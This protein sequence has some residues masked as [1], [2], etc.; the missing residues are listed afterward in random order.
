MRQHGGV[1]AR[2]EVRLLGGFSVRRGGEE[3]APGAFRGRLVRSLIRVLL[4]RRG[5]FVSHD[6]LA[7]ALWPGRMPA[8]P[9]ANLKVLVNRARA[10]L[11][12][13]ALI[14][15]G[16]G[17]YSFTGGDACRV[18]AEEFVA[19]AA[20]GRR[21]LHEGDAV[22]AL[23]V[24]G[25]A[26]E[27]WG[28]EPLPEEAYEDWAREYRAGLARAHLQAV[29]DA[30][31]AA[32]AVGE[33][34]DAV[35]LA[36]VATTREPLREV[37]H[38]LLAEAQVASGDVVGALRTIDGLRRRLGHET[39]LEPSA[40]ILDLERR[41][42]RGHS[43]P[44]PVR[45]KAARPSRPA[46]GGQLTFVGRNAELASVLAAIGE[47][48]PGV[49]VVTGPAGAGKSRLL[50]EAASRCA[51]SVVSVRAFQAERNEP[52]SLARALLRDALSLDLAAA[53]SLADRT[54]AAL[55]DLLP[56]LE[57]LRPL[58]VAVVDPE[59]R[60]ALAVE[61]AV[62]LVS[63]VAAK[64]LLV[65]VDDLQWADPTSI[66]LLGLIG[67]RVPAAALALSYRPTEVQPEGPLG[68]FLED[69]GAARSVTEV[70]VGPFSPSILGELV[71][72]PVL[73]ESLARQTDGTPLAVSEV[74][75]RL[76]DD[77]AIALEAD[78]RWRPVRPGVAE[79]AGTIAREGQRR[80]IERRAAR[81]PPGERETLALLALLGREVPA[82]LLAAARNC[83]EAV[84][85]DELDGLARTG[86]IRLGDAGWATA[87]DLIAEAVTDALGREER[88]RLHHQLARALA[89][90][91]EDPAEVARHLAEAGDRAAAAEAFAAA[92]GQRMERYAA[93]ETA[94]LADAGLAL[95]PAGALRV[96]LL[97][98]RA[99]ARNMQ[100]DGIGARHDLRRALDELRDERDRSRLLTKLAIFSVSQ[101]ASEATALAEAAIAEAGSDLRA[102]ANALVAAG[103][104]VG[105]SDRTAEA[106]V[107]ITE[108]RLLFEDA[109]DSRGLAST[110]DAQANAL[111]VRGRLAEAVPFYQRAARLYR[112]TGQLAKVGW[113][114]LIEAF[115]LNM[116]GRREAARA[117]CAEAL[118]VERA[119]GQI[120]GEAGC[121]V[122][123]ADIAI[124]SGDVDDARRRLP[125]ALRLS[126]AAGNLEFI[127]YALILAGRVARADGDPKAAES[128]FQQALGA[129]TGLPLWEAQAAAH[130]ADLYLSRNN[131][132][133]A[134]AF[135]R[136]ACAGRVGPGP[137]EGR[138]LLAETA[139]ARGDPGAEAQARQ[140]LQAAATTDYAPSPNRLRLQ[141]RLDEGKMGGPQPMAS[142]RLRRVFMFT[143]I[144]GSSNLV[145]L[146][147]DEA[148]DHLLRW[149]DHTLRDLFA[150]HAGEEINRLG[151]GF[152]VAFEGPEAA[153][154]CAIAIQQALSAHRRDHGFAP[155]VRIGI[156]TAEATHQDGDYQ[157]QGVHQA[158]RIGS[159]ASAGEILVSRSTLGDL[160]RFRCSPPRAIALKGFSD[161]VLVVAVE[162]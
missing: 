9:V 65:A 151:D 139:F 162:W 43:G 104:A 3:I 108:A 146:L 105:A 50:Q 121:L 73:A 31:R 76:A 69:L 20:D 78:G 59:S 17:G 122:G 148:W 72:D 137:I 81:R 153:V 84:V 25:P 2:T 131:F 60:R 41:I 62:R 123:L 57:E 96:A 144:V 21:R 117:R 30:A 89:G 47:S 22:G 80:G 6:V 63:V 98:R 152:F 91:E 126:R 125:D 141:R 119:L 99:D 154:S 18:D 158:A 54:A 115:A 53:A 112:D 106:D 10:G 79:L 34:D 103:F 118:E 14:V 28:G 155:V 44:A 149:H 113:P 142:T 24:L 134:E 4:T 49:T 128:A 88:G 70:G 46:F 48:P 85:L 150:R 94:T 107:F 61:G 90:A 156:H 58:T 39:G 56:E 7:E 74:I 143:D 87:H 37:A 124:E 27:G 77:G 160:E 110:A 67:R 116:L 13:P 64:G 100:G 68:A 82:R 55:A 127:S 33:A 71:T 42:Q 15:T 114:I 1:E 97:E 36:E 5:T 92:A 23:A 86:L 133:E 135:A 38:V 19:A 45:S 101:D 161:P 147:G 102:K 8:D 12:D 32:L 120:E 140:A 11:G 29:E 83:R 40:A 52:W 51:H 111:F 35:A 159:A 130:L 145:E 136:R 75:R 95:E 16:P 157:G 129:A 26:L 132:D 66:V 93:D 138:I 109:G